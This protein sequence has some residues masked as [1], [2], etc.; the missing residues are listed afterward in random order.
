MTQPVLT[1]CPTGRCAE[2]STSARAAD[3]LSA[4]RRCGPTGGVAQRE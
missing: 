2:R 3:R 1:A 4:G